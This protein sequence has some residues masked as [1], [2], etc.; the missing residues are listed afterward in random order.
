V[1]CQLSAGSA[2]YSV[3]V[4]IKLAVFDNKKS[5]IKRAR[6][7]RLHIGIYIDRKSSEWVV[8]VGGGRWSAIAKASSFTSGCEI[9]SGRRRRTGRVINYCRSSHQDDLP[10]SKSPP[11]SSRSGRT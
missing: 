11:N 8:G 7:Q 3:V 4:V 9:V 1:I 6:S 10:A 5:T 2:R